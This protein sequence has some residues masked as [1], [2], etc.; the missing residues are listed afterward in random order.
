MRVIDITGEHSLNLFGDQVKN[1]FGID[2]KAYSDLIENNE[3]EKLKEITNKIEYHSFY[4]YGKA[5]IFKFGNRIKT[6]LFVYKIE[7]E[8]F[9][10]EKRKIFEDIQKTLNNIK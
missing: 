2:A 7:E 10:K 8:D 5:N 4:F 1:L 3:V 6:Q 9:K